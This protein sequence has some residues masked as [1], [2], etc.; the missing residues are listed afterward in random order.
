MLDYTTKSALNMIC[1][2]YWRNIDN[3]QLYENENVATVIIV[4]LEV[5]EKSILIKWSDFILHIYWN[6]KLFKSDSSE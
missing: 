3:E 2:E 4:V 5:A 1:G 6:K